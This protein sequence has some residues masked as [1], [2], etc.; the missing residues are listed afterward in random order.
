MSILRGKNMGTEIKNI[1]MINKETGEKTK[2]ALLPSIEKDEVKYNQKFTKDKEPK[3][4][5]HLSSKPHTVTFENMYVDWV[6]FYEALLGVQF[7]SYQKIY[8]RLQSRLFY[9][10][11]TGKW[12]RRTK[13]N[14]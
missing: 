3:I 12:I 13:H 7:K 4:I 6:T 8:L 10:F 1:F 11:K 14:D 2:T 9:F 5:M